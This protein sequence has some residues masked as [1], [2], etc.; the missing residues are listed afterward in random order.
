MEIWRT[1]S[2]KKCNPQRT[3]ELMNS[4]ADMRMPA[5]PGRSRSQDPRLVPPASHPIAENFLNIVEE[6]IDEVM[7]REMYGNFIDNFPEIE[8]PKQVKDPDLEETEDEP[9]AADAVKAILDAIT[10]VAKKSN[11]N[12]DEDEE[13]EETSAMGAAAVE[14][15]AGKRDKKKETLIREV[16]DYLFSTLGDIL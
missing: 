9:T 10:T 6:T 1:F 13:L 8:Y 2:C 14:V 5:D 7:P 3:A 12:I 11:I 16:E 4:L 15:G